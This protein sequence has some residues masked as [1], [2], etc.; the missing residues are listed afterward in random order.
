MSN[1]GTEP[2]PLW[3][4]LAV[5]EYNALRGEI[6]ATM[7]TQDG[8][9]RFSAATVGI[10]LTGGFN[11]WK[12]Q[13]PAA[14]IFLVVVPYLCTMGLIVWMGEV[15]RMMRAGNHV[16][17][18]EDMFLEHVPGVP[19]PVMRWEKNLRDP[20]AKGTRWRRHYEWNYLAIVLM[21][22]SLGVASIVA[23]VYRALRP[24]PDL[25]SPTTVW[26]AAG[27]FLGLM[28]VGLFLFLRKLATVCDTQGRLSFLKKLYLAGLRGVDASASD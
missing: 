17:L 11:V 4:E 19:E 26:V 25:W 8:T 23:G 6:L 1:L 20:T 24:H 27:I 14:L 13:L 7:A 22:W 12:H 16:R 21:F 18:L 2:K 28:A 15:T 10:V 5:Q 9:L 3:F